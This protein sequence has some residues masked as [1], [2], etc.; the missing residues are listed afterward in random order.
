MKT[1]QT[2]PERGIK[3]KTLFTVTP[4]GIPLDVQTG[5]EELFFNLV[6]SETNEPIEVESGVDVGIDTTSAE[7]RAWLHQQLDNYLD[8]FNK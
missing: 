6:N 2:K 4:S 5:R 7:S 8:S 1:S 3:M